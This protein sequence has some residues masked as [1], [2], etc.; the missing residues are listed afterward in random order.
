MFLS[1]ILLDSFYLSKKIENSKETVP[2]LRQLSLKT[3]ISNWSHF[4]YI[5]E[6]PGKTQKIEILSTKYAAEKFFL[7]QKR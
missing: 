2:Y 1:L 5:S 3:I 6:L 7:S 4:P